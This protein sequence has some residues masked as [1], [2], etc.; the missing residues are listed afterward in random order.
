M[1]SCPRPRQRGGLAVTPVAAQQQGFGQRHVVAALD[2]HPGP[3]Q[4]R[5]E[6]GAGRPHPPNVAGPLPRRHH[7]RQIFVPYD[8]PGARLVPHGLGQPAA[9]LR[10]GDDSNPHTSRF[11]ARPRTI[12]AASG[13]PTRNRAQPGH[14]DRRTGLGPRTRPTDGQRIA[15]ARRF[16]RGSRVTEHNKPRQ[17]SLGR[18]PA[19]G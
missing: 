14:R 17:A 13:K 10:L 7:G 15:A 3:Q 5:V 9:A 11:S 6:L 4:L 12:P 8:A 2:P 18:L 1:Q 19:G 16:G